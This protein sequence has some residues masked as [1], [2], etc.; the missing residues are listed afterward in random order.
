MTVTKTVLIVDDN[1]DIV[2]SIKESLIEHGLRHNYI[3]APDGKKACSIMEKKHVDLVILDLMM[4]GMDGWELV[5]WMNKNEPTKTTPVMIVTAKTDMA[6]RLMGNIVCEYYIMKPIDPGDLK[7]KV[8]S[9]L[10]R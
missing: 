7:S 9:I 10:G 4:P 5:S 6:N 3:S 8:E 2:F 1:A